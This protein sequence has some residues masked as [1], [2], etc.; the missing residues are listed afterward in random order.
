MLAQELQ[1][2]ESVI[3]AY[4]LSSDKRVR[5]Q[6]KNKYLGVLMMRAAENGNVD[7]MEDC[8]SH[9]QKGK[10]KDSAWFDRMS[11]VALSLM[12]KNTTLLHHLLESV[13]EYSAAQCFYS[14]LEMSCRAQDLSLFDQT[15]MYVREK[16][17]PLKLR[18]FN[19]CHIL[20]ARNDLERLR[21]MDDVFDLRSERCYKTIG[22]YAIANNAKNVV[23]NFILQGNHKLENHVAW[24]KSCVDLAPLDRRAMARSIFNTVSVSNRPSVLVEYLNHSSK[25]AAQMLDLTIDVAECFDVLTEWQRCHVVLVLDKNAQSHNESIEYIKNRWE[26]N[27]ICQA[28]EEQLVDK[29]DMG[30][31]AA[32]KI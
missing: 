11:C 20:A 14:L 18:N 5:D 6:H 13:E 29:K 31:A 16:S 28:I 27:A 15:W 12:N 10:H 21:K 32:R 7:L 26:K 17:M 30:P 4:D 9:A 1:N 2:F 23:D 24:F 25:E 3:S 22:M 8:Y 19:F